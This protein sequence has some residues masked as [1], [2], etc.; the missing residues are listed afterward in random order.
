MVRDLRRRRLGGGPRGGIGRRPDIRRD[1]EIALS[2]GF[3]SRRLLYA[4]LSSRELS[5]LRAAWALEPRSGFRGD[6]QAGTVAAAIY[7]VNRKKGS[8][9][10]D[11]LD[12]TPDYDDPAQYEESPLA[13]IS[14][15]EADQVS[16]Q[17]V[18]WAEQFQ[19]KE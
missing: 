8:E 5:E 9:S 18:A 1:W 17:L 7:N 11:A 19:K 14:E 16:D 15:E 3:P 4:V 13:E 12:L 2:L 6:L 10:L